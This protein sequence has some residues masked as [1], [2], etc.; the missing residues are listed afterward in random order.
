[1]N[2]DAVG[3]L[4][5][6]IGAIAV[7]ISVIYL[8]TQIRENTRST[9]VN[10]V[11]ESI[12]AYSELYRI[13]ATTPDL[14]GIIIRGRASMT[15][16]S[17]E[18]AIRF[19][20]YYSMAFQILEGWYTASDLASS[21][22]REQIEVTETILKNHLLDRGVREWWELNRAEFPKSFVNWVDTTG[23]PSTEAN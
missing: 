7:V 23:A 9:V 22:P 10:V 14:A 17:S 8:A 6:M 11:K 20:S 1:M 16:L 18:E 13:V 19:D 4:S 2:W 3:A 15:N 12:D 21:F 5:E